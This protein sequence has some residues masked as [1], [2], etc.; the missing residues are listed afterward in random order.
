MYYSLLTKSAM[1]WWKTV[2]DVLTGVTTLFWLVLSSLM[3]V[4]VSSSMFSNVTLS[5]GSSIK[6]LALSSLSVVNN[7]LVSS[8]SMLIAVVETYKE[9]II[10]CSLVLTL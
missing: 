10:R 9:T 1:D 6:R 5:V 3:N 8:L 2:V 7:C 4:S